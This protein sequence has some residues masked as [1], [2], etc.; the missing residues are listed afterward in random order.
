MWENGKDHRAQSNNSILFYSKPKKKELTELFDM[1]NLG[2]NGEPGFVNA[3]HM[4]D[5][6]PWA[7]GLNPCFE[8]L[9]A[10]GNTCNLVTIDLA[11][12]KDD[13]SGLFEAV[14]LISRANYRQTVVDFRDG[15]LQ[16]KW[17][18]NNDHLHLC[19]V[20]LMGI[21]MRPDMQPYDFKRIERVA[22]QSAYNMAD[23]LGTPHSKNITA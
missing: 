5:R 22:T 4:L 21:A 13:N 16:E 20:S 17:N 15:I 6:A 8:I 10:D 23:E 14:R 11:K 9:L 2:G 18:L 19:G 7:K 3:R 1:L 12:F